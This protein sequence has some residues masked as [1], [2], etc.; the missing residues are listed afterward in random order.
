[1]NS[2]KLLRDLKTV[3]VC[4]MAAALC[5]CASMLSLNVA[6]AEP[7]TQPTAAVERVWEYGAPLLAQDITQ[8]GRG[9]EIV[10]VTSLASD[11]PGTL[12]DAVSRPGP[13]ISPAR[14]LRSQ[15]PSSQS[16]VRLRPHLVSRL[17]EA[18]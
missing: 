8:G 9:G 13:R 6:S 17:S 14:K 1:M 7:A 3:S 12:R 15:S 11:G 10:R 2:A 18:D 4:V 16:P 5:G